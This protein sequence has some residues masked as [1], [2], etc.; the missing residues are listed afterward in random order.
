TLSPT[1]RGSTAGTGPA[2]P[3]APP[4]QQAGLQGVLRG[5]GDSPPPPRGARPENAPPAP[6]AGCPLHPPPNGGAHPRGRAFRTQFPASVV[7]GV[8]DPARPSA[9]ADAIRAGVFDVLPRPPSAR[10]LEALLANAREQATL[11]ASQTA[12]PAAEAMPYG[13]VG[14]SPAMR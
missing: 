2:P 11:A 10:D 3:L 8:A 5:R 1:Q 14:T 9:A 7:I 4:S 13:I 6:A 12:K